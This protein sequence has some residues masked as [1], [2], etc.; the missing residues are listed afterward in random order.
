MIIENRLYLCEDHNII[1]ITLNI[2]ERNIQSMIEK[3]GARILAKKQIILDFNHRAGYVYA[4]SIR[5]RFGKI[6]DFLTKKSLLEANNSKDYINLLY[7]SR[8]IG[9]SSSMCFIDKC[10][11]YTFG[12]CSS[13]NNYTPSS[14]YWYM[15]GRMIHL[16]DTFRTNYG[17]KRYLK[18]AGRWVSNRKF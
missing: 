4:C 9:Y 11:L 12:D 15:D 8:C 3:T 16:N 18:N 14:P 13:Y 2:P 7:D 1:D 10:G 5:V 6:K 17:K